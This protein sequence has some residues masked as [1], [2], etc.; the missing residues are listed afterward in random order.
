MPGIFVIGGAL[1]AGVAGLLV[2][3]LVLW[4][5]YA[6]TGRIVSVPFLLSIVIMLLLGSLLLPRA[7]VRQLPALP[8]VGGIGRLGWIILLAAAMLLWMVISALL[9]SGRNEP[10]PVARR[11]ANR[12]ERLSRTWTAILGILATTAVSILVVALSEGAMLTGE[13]AQFVA[14]APLISSNLFAVGAAYVG[15]GGS[16]DLPVVG[17]VG[18]STPASPAIVA[19]VIALGFTLAVGVTYAD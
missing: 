3:G 8:S 7:I 12:V 11:V 4:A 9:G 10:E 17:T 2:A 19:G 5:V 15:L 6:K 13:L 16:V 14:D 1:A 18:L